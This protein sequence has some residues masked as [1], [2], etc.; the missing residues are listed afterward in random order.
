MAKASEKMKTAKVKKPLSKEELEMAA[1]FNWLGR[2]CPAN[3]DMTDWLE[4]EKKM[5]NGPAP[6]KK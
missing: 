2:G 5:E 1:Y 4:A 6:G 3:D